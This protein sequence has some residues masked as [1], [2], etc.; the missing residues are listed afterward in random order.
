[1]NRLLSFLV[2]LFSACPSFIFSQQVELKKWTFNSELDSQRQIVEIPHTW[3]KLDAFDDE[4]GYWRGKGFY[5]TKI[6]ISDTKK[7]YFLHFNGV[8]QYTKVWVNDMLAGEHK[9]GY[10]AFDINITKC[11]KRGENTIAVEVDNTHNETIPPLDADFTFYGGIYR[12]VYLCQENSAYF[13]KKY[14]A[15]AIKIEPFL[16]ENWQGKLEIN[17]SVFCADKKQENYKV[18]LILRDT[19]NKIITTLKKTIDPNFNIIFNL[20]APLLWSPQSPNLYSIEL[21][22]LDRNGK[23]LDVYKHKAGFRKFEANTSGFYLNGKLLKLMGVNRHQDFEGDGNAVP[24]QKQIEDLILIKNMGSNFLRLAHYPQDEAIYKAA[25]SLGLIIWSEIPVINKVPIDSS[26]LEYKENAVQMQKEHIYQNYNHPSLVFIGYMNEIFIRLIF[27]K[28][29]VNAQKEIV[30]K[31]MELA[32]TLEI[33]T[34]KEAPNHI[35]V[36][37][38]HG[39]QI[40]NDSGIANIPMVI[41]WNLYYG[42]YEGQSKDL[43]RFLDEENLKFPNRPLIISE[44]G[45]G[46]DQRLH[47]SNPKKFDFS[48]EYQFDYHPAYYEQVKKRPF[49]LGMTA[50]NFADFGSEFRGD[51]IPHVNQ[52]GLVNFN[53]SPKNIYYWYKAILKPEEKQSRFFKELETH[54][55]ESPQKEIIIISNEKVFFKLNSN[56]SVKLEPN[57]GLIKHSITLEEDSNILLLLNELNQLQDSICIKYAKPNLEKCDSLAISF[58]TENYFIDDTNQIWIPYHQQSILKIAGNVK[59]VSS[60]ANIKNTLNDPIYQSSVQN[61]KK[62]KIELPKEIYTITLL[63]SELQANKTLVYELNKNMEDSPIKNLAQKIKIND[64]VISVEKLKPF[65][66]TEIKATID[67][68]DYLIIEPTDESQKISICGIKIK[69]N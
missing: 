14:G 45:V 65:A 39:N 29:E 67:V 38:L 18:Q 40:Y 15:D 33:L 12:N 20:K 2:A 26:Y 49:V 59:N 55:S 69:R 28:P 48:E 58:G 53:R 16:D 8:N 50:W 56:E 5:N 24:I 25:D 34:R 13:E 1:M 32:Q 36:M 68:Q 61:V 43:G 66:K 3:N 63:F 52:K 17:G 31:T 19:N 41:G 22:L 62:I 57:N 9:G 35:T 42:W 27:D 51:A 10:T 11:L 54:L 30:K 44:Y 37:A 23:I 6:A 46:A 64:T 4:A 47:N 21:N 7:T 60:S